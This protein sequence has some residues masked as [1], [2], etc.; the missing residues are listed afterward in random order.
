[1]KV[2]KIT[3]PPHEIKRE[4]AFGGDMR[5]NL[6]ASYR[7]CIDMAEKAKEVIANL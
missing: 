2:F 7:W 3:G 6:D 1:M 5:P 4:N